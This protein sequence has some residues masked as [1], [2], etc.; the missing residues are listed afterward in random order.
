MSDDGADV[1]R[2]WGRP[3]PAVA[4]VRSAV[5]ATL[6][7][8]DPGDLVLV[9]CSGGG[10]SM[11]LA[12]AARFEGERAGVR[13]GAV[14]V[15][16]GLQE[17]SRERRRGGRRLGCARSTSTPCTW[18]RAGRWRSTAAPT[19]SR[20]WPAPPATAS[21]TRPPSTSA[22]ASS[23]SATPATT[24]PSRCS[25][26]WPAAPAPA[27]SPG[28]PPPAAATGAPSSAVSRRAV[29]R[30][31]CDAEG[32]AWWD[33]PMNEDPA[34][35]RV[36]ARRA[37]ADLEARP[38]PG[39][40][41]RAGPQRRPAARRRRPPR[42]P[43]RRG[44]RRPRPR[45]VAGRRPR[46]AAAPRSVAAPGAASSSPPAPPPGRSRAGTPTPATGSLTHWHGQGAVHAPGG[47]RVSRSDGR[48][49]IHPDR[50]G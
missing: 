37:L 50:S 16:H 14:V 25:S 29:P 32:I 1:T 5:R 23:S 20:R 34:F 3:H 24:R 36:R 4:A 11:A 21:S 48:V 39:P 27:A 2:A 40:G 15:D 22:P 10:D 43:R 12:D 38:R 47:L 8:C 7:E 44:R 6:A 28:C 31:A 35:T 18:C 9:A 19:A 17:G 45:P 46:R 42:P 41:R 26:A 13:V 49:S 30:A 33:D